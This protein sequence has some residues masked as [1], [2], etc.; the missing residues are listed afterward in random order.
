[1]KKN[2]KIFL[3]IL[4]LVTLW[5]PKNIYAAEKTLSEVEVTFTSAGSPVF[6]NKFTIKNLQ[7]AY[8]KIKEG[9]ITS[10][11]V[12]SAAWQL[13]EQQRGVIVGETF[14]INPG[15]QHTSEEA[16]SILRNMC[17]SGAI[18]LVDEL[19][20]NPS[21]VAPFHY[22]ENIARRYT[23]NKGKAVA[24]TEVGI[25]GIF[26]NDDNL[27]QLVRVKEGS[28]TKLSIDI[29]STTNLFDGKIGNLSDNMKAN[30]NSYTVEFGQE[31]IYQLTINKSLL[32]QDLP[33]TINPQTNLVIDDIS[34]PFSKIPVYGDVISL[35]SL[36]I[37]ADSSISPSASLA[38]L[39]SQIQTKFSQNMLWGY[40]VTI[41]QSDTDITVTIKAHI[42]PEVTLKSELQ[43]VATD[44]SLTP[45]EF[46]I[47]D[48]DLN[49][50]TNF[51][52]N[53]VATTTTGS[54]DYSMPMVRT[55]GINFA[56]VDPSG[57]KLGGKENY[58]LGYE[59]ND[60]KYIYGNNQWNLVSNLENIDLNTVQTFSGGNQY[61]LGG[62]VTAIPVN[63]KLFSFNLIK[64]RK[65]NESLIKFTGLG[66]G[67]K[68]FLYPIDS[69]HLE[70]KEIPFTT[71]NKDFLRSN[72]QEVTQTSIGSA[73]YE[74]S[75]I[76][77]L[78]PDYKAGSVEYNVTVS[79]QNSATALFGIIIKIVGMCLLI[80]AI[81]IAICWKG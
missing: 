54:L 63:T 39:K 6:N 41:P 70:K 67:R 38:V 16:E 26:D 9:K 5:L 10:A 42:A 66:Q 53:I 68:Y 73:Q 59:E 69:K 62:A 61:Y 79:N 72:G 71:Y 49:S 24:T 33:L 12:H 56:S 18:D 78:I 48:I 81:L 17:N 37:T 23:N 20:N 1:M 50:K 15:I 36:G 8:D 19:N 2:L 76:N 43:G 65:A 40:A 57:T 29:N 55:S 60:R 35:Q 28:P 47:G 25:N 14:G 74:D 34:V 13:A 27:I 52:M 21:S 31:L 22:P 77:S 46:V 4:F 45:M 3:L 80:I 58:L 30:D 51:F 32:A 11:D 75:S 7:N 44:G 64:N